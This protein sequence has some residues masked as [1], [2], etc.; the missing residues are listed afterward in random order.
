M[1][2]SQQWKAAVVAIASFVLTVCLGWL[3]PNRVF[4]VKPFGIANYTMSACE[5]ASDEMGLDPTCKGRPYTQAGGT[6]YEF[7]VKIA[8]NSRIIEFSHDRLLVSSGGNPKDVA[9]NFPPGLLFDPLATPTCPIA[10]FND[11][12]QTCPANTQVGTALLVMQGGF[13]SLSPFYNITP[14]LGRPAEFGI[15]STSNVNF[16]VGGS[17]RTGED[18]GVSGIS[19]GI[20]TF[21][22]LVS[23][24]LTLWGTPAD[25]RHDSQRGLKC[26]WNTP[27]TGPPEPT[28]DCHG[29]GLADGDRPIALVRMPTYCSGESLVGEAAADSWE[30]PGLLNANGSRNQADPSWKSVTTL[31]PPVSGCNVLNFDSSLVVQPDTT[32]TGE[33]VGLSINMDVPQTEDPS[34]TTTP[35]VRD[36]K[37]TLPSGTVVSPS[38]AQGLSTC[39]DDPG[40]DPRVVPNELGPS[41]LSPASCVANSQVGTVHV[42][43]PDLAQPLDGQVFLGTP[44]CGLCSPD[45]A[46][47]GRMV[48]MYLQLIGEGSDGLTVKL[49]GSGSINQKTGQVT[50]SFIDNP[51]LPFDHLTVSLGG[52]PRATLA[53]P[54]TCGPAVSSADLTPW[55]SPF[56]PDSTSFSEYNVTDCPPAQFS[57]KFT[58]GT[59]SNQAGG[60]SPF[61]LAIERTDADG[62]FDSVQTQMPTGLLGMLS[63]VSLCGEPQAALGTCGPQ[64]LI[65]HTQ[66]LTGPGAEP[67][68]VTGGQVFITGPY[69]GAP[70]GLSIVVPAKAG[71][72]TLTGTTGTGTVV[73]RAAINVDPGDAHLVVTTDPVPNRLDGIP[74]QLKVI[75]VEIDR[76]NFVFNPTSCNRLTIDG[77]L[78]SVDG[79]LAR[80][81]APFQVTNCR[82]L[83]FKPRFQVKTSGRNSRVKGASLVAKLSYP[84]S[85][86]G[87]ESNV[88]M[89]KV[90]LPRQLPSRLTTLQKACPSQTFDLNPALCPSAS[91]VGQAVANTPVMPHPLDGPAYFVSHGGAAFPDL[92]IVLQGEGV[93]VNLV[94]STFISNSKITS[95][96][97]HSVPDVPVRTFELSLP[98]GRYSALAAVGNLCA[99]AAG[100]TTHR[101]GGLKMPTAFVA[102]DGEVIHRNTVIS[103]GGCPKHIASKRGR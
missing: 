65:G 100:K 3:V 7:T 92:I 37:L 86:Q 33:P 5:D 80:A 17:V 51:Q 95:S 54:R 57:P 58:A 103:V 75:N 56:T 20:P 41:S 27:F 53:N 11:R 8:L 97:F 49:E 62:F 34:L 13:T 1:M 66:V 77:A 38:A 44:L 48:R 71:P 78:S 81:S 50:A 14:Q 79:A 23:S 12:S 47:E 43:S 6:P 96:T 74:L 91:R 76:P 40:V 22:N 45:D 18:Y 72:Y 55:S 83:S 24:T 26:N 4:A 67:Y 102:Q 94:G 46:R 39:R 2:F 10:V 64:S 59:P 84:S 36:V 68:L 93:H 32:A 16:V 52:G 21:A 31:M 88:A 101:R 89:V 30:S 28:I 35:H 69:K 15:A 9:V 42:T 73:V 98:Q 63:S 60:F 82:A 85:P 70:Y 25:P 19:S 87:T 99:I 61:T 29:G 90:D